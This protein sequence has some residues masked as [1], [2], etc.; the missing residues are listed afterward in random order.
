MLNHLLHR[1]IL[2]ELPVLIA[3]HAIIFVLTSVGIGAEDIL[4]E[5]HSAA[6]AKSL[7]HILFLFVIIINNI[8]PRSIFVV[9]IDLHVW[10]HV[11]IIHRCSIRTSKELARDA[12]QNTRIG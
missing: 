2:Q 7:F 1:T 10:L 9:K 11:F 6:L 5:R 3:V 8:F 4:C 12:S